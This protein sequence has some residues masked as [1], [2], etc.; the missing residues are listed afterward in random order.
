MDNFSA[1]VR[2]ELGE[3]E[4]VLWSGRP[5][6]M[7]L[8]DPPYGSPIIIRW[9]VCLIIVC[10][11]AWYRFIFY[12]SAQS[13]SVN[14][15]VVLV[16]IVVIAALIALMPLKDMFALKKRCFYFITDR[17]ALLLFTG[18]SSFLKEKKYSDVSGVTHDLHAADRGN[19]YVGERLKNSSQKARATA[20]T[21]PH[22]DDADKP[23]VFYSV[24]NPKE[25]SGFFPDSVRK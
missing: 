15:N 22:D 25:V 6:G 20:L 11:G 7:K 19:V 18:T 1:L 4:V 10:F 5:A 3:D 12:P 14:A 17:R 13:S 9:V 23:L 2:D 8:L 24:M 16:V 21:R